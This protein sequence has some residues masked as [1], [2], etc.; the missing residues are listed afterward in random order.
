MEERDDGGKEGE[1]EREREG[2]C[3]RASVRALHRVALF[4]GCE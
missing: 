4:N 3:L 1:A 2:C